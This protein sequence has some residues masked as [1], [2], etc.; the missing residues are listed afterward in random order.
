MD[1]ENM[2]LTATIFVTDKCNLACKYCYEENKQFQTTTKENIYD[3]IHFLFEDPQYSKRPYLILDFIGGEAL[4]EWPLME[5]GIKLFLSEGKRRKHPWVINHRFSL[6]TCTNGTLFSNPDIKEFLSRWPNLHVGM[7]LDG[8]K[9]AHDMNRVYLNG[10]GSYD[11]IME[12]FN[13]WKEHYPEQNI[14]KGTMNRDTLPLLGDMLI[15]QIDL[16]MEP[17]ANPIYEEKWTEKDA[18]IYYK[19]LCKVIDFVFHRKLYLRLPPIGRR[20]M[21]DKDKSELET[22][23]YCGSGTCMVTLGMDGKLYPCHRFAT[24]KHKF[25]IGDVKH[26]ID[27]ER[28]REFRNGEIRINKQVGTT[29][30]PLCYAAN[31]DLHG[32]FNYYN[33]TEIMTKAEYRAYDYWMKRMR[34]ISL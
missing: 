10:K 18:E 8:N 34:E 28:M 26:G 17:W 32:D 12:T 21:P 22:G 16:G 2:P 25:S 14:V 27:H 3:F 30:Q 5:Y 13:W 19:Q 11:T 23:G 20:R 31:Y 29:S 7:S 9:K 24:A 15:N 1:Y 4:L 33:N 6:S